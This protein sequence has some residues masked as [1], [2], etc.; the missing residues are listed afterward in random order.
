MIEEVQ[1]IIESTDNTRMKEVV[2]LEDRL[3]GLEQLMFGARK[4]VQEQSDMA[5]GFVQNQNRARSLSDPSVLPD[6]CQVH[7]GQMCAM[8]KNHQSM[9]DIKRRC[10]LAKEELSVNLHTRLRSVTYLNSS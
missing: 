4:L 7:R 5:Q 1:K 9:R 6:L 3:S 2:G 8:L 10:T